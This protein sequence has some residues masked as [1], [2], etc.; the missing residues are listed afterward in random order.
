MKKD[1]KSLADLNNLE[2]QQ[3]VKRREGIFIYFLLCINS[4]IDW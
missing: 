1:N 2:L 4:N 3:E